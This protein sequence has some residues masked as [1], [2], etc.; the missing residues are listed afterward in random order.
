MLCIPEPDL[1]LAPDSSQRPDEI[2]AK[3]LIAP[4][5]FV[6][7]EASSYRRGVFIPASFSDPHHSPL[8][9]DIIRA[10][11]FNPGGKGGV[12]REIT[13]TGLRTLDGSLFGSSK[14]MGWYRRIWYAMQDKSV[15]FSRPR[16]QVPLFS[17]TSQGWSLTEAG[18]ATAVK[19]RRHFTTHSNTTAVWLNGQLQGEF[20]KRLTDNLQYD[21]RLTKERAAGELLDHVH[22]YF[23]DA[24]RLDAFQ[25]RLEHGEP[26][27]LKQIADWIGRKA[28]S[29][30]RQYGRDGLQRAIR[31][32]LTSPERAAGEVTREAMAPST[33]QVVLQGGEED[34]SDEGA[35]TQVLVDTEAQSALHL[36]AWEEGMRQVRD[37]I[38]RQ[39]PGAPER[40]VGVFEQMCA[41]CNAPTI[42]T[43]QGVSRNRAASLMADTREAVRA[44]AQTAQDARI[45]LTYVREEPFASLA[46]FRE[47]RDDPDA[48]S[49]SM[50]V[51]TRI[52]WLVQ[53]L[54]KAERLEDHGDS[55]TIT[56]RGESYLAEFALFAHTEGNYGIRVAL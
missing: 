8:R 56:N 34:G 31:G 11:G 21:P 7:G 47:Q 5:L 16:K 3:H 46:D 23:A 29:T 35:P 17:H 12:L 19:I 27:T 54:V 10:A 24:I 15:Q 45:L 50:A 55:F 25:P 42:G 44:A 37:A 38:R 18:V 6:L 20:L 49:P 30:F 22:S 14:P 4:V 28:I 2:T 52:A 51:D 39:K 41:D 36:I 1:S 53:E 9:D 26:P 40:Y 13:F 48:E 33:Y 32:A 43:L